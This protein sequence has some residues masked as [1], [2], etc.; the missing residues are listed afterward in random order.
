MCRPRSA[1]TRPRLC[2]DAG[3]SVGASSTGCWAGRCADAAGTCAGASGRSPDAA[4]GQGAVRVRADRGRRAA[5]RGSWGYAPRDA[6]GQCGLAPPRTHSPRTGHPGVVTGSG[7]STHGEL[8]PRGA[9]RHGQQ[10]GG[11]ACQASGEGGG[12][13]TRCVVRVRCRQ[14]GRQ[15]CGMPLILERREHPGTFLGVV[16]PSERDL[17]PL[18]HGFSP[19]RA[20]VTGPEGVRLNATMEADHPAK[21]LRVRVAARGIAACSSNVSAPGLW[22]MVRHKAVLER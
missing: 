17:N 9:W 16:C 8:R 11:G 2:R 21:R 18:A 5:V 19:C 7:L 3:S 14:R 6:T 15:S 20:Y 13:E 22:P 1:P 4:A 10:A 12:G